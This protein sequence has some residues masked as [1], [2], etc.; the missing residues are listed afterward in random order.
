[1][2]KRKSDYSHGQMEYIKALG[3]PCPIGEKI[4]SPVRGKYHVVTRFEWREPFTLLAVL[5]DGTKVR[6][7]E[8]LASNERRRQIKEFFRS[9]S[10]SYVAS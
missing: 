5:D 9:H 2:A 7:Y 1:M 10:E 4:L 8:D 3:T 6:D